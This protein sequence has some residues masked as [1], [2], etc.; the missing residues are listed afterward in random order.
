MVSQSLGQGP[1]HAH[2]LVVMA[3][4]G[5]PR[6]Q[7]LH[8]ARIR[9]KLAS[10]RA[11]VWYGTRSRRRW[12]CARGHA[13]RRRAS[14]AP[15]LVTSIPPYNLV[16]R[17][18][19]KGLILKSKAAAA[20]HNIPFKAQIRKTKPGPKNCRDVCWAGDVAVTDFRVSYDSGRF[21]EVARTTAGKNETRWK[22]GPTPKCLQ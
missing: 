6:E 2:H 13:P 11:L 18:R 1:G 3:S 8:L 4:F 21:G 9:G 14:R 19:S 15:C 20:Q 12:A 10:A 22:P 7:T 5:D 17:A 16:A